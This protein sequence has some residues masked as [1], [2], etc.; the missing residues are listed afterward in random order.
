MQKLLV[1]SIAGLPGVT[2]TLLVKVQPGAS[3]MNPPWIPPVTW[4]L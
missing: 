2:A 3:H 4:L 1:Y